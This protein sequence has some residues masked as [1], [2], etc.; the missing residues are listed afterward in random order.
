MSDI[1]IFG[2]TGQLARELA[3]LAPDASFLGRD[4]A[5]LTDPAACADAMAHTCMSAIC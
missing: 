5:D 4:A 3:A 2:R 1:L